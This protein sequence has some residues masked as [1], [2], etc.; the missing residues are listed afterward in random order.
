[1]LMAGFYA[2]AQAA[3]LKKLVLRPISDPDTLDDVPD[4]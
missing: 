4:L 3:A 1:M 2:F